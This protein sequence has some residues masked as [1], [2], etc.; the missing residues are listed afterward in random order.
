MRCPRG[1][2]RVWILGAGFSR[3]LGGPLYNELLRLW[4]PSDMEALGLSTET[5]LVAE[6]FHGRRATTKEQM[7]QKIPWNDVEQFLEKLSIAIEVPDSVARLDIN[8]LLTG[9]ELTELDLAHLK[10]QALKRIAIEVSVFLRGLDEESERFIPYKR[11][12]MQLDGHDTIVTFNYDSVLDALAIMG[13][14]IR[15]MPRNTEVQD[16]LSEVAYARALPLH[17]SLSWFH[18]SDSVHGLGYVPTDRPPPLGIP[19]R[20]KRVFEK[21][22]LWEA[23][24]IA[25][26]NADCVYFL[27]YR[28]P[29]TDSAAM[30]LIC[31]AIRPVQSKFVHLVLG[32]DATSSSRLIRILRGVTDHLFTEELE[33]LDTQMMVEEFL[34]LYN[35]P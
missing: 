13:C 32:T 1:S 27:G 11:W 7:S 35:R 6:V 24:S 2:K 12:A 3:F 9:L 20:S 33:I 18:K 5:S 26:T 23:A 30:R 34:S 31:D 8:R 16:V 22:P 10:E 19:G 14:P 28:L 4:T 17:G 15:V 29:E 25:L 21:T